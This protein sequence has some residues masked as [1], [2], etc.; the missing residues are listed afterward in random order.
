WDN[1]FIIKG[2]KDAAEI[3]K[4][5]GNEEEYERIS[6]I[7]DTFTTSLY[8]SINLA[9]KVRGIDYIPGCVELGDFDATS[10]TVALTPC[11]ELKNLP[12]P[13]VFNTFEK[14][15][16]FFLN[17]KNGNLD[18]INYTP[19]E[20]RLIGSYILLDQPDRAHELIAF[21]L[22]DQRPPGW[23]HWAEIVWNDF[24]KPN[25]IG[26]MPHTW[27]GSDFIN[28]IRSMFVYENEYDASLVIASALY[29]EWIDDP[30][31]MAVNNLPTYFGNLNYE[32]LKSGNSYHFDITGD[33]KLPSNGIKI[34]NFNSKKMPKAVWINGKNSTEFSADEISVRVFP[35]ELIIE[36]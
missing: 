1:F 27:V 22:D 30:D 29:Q 14:Y 36:Y 7:R 34:K 2:L 15:Y 6:K 26:D 32:I 21:F 33:L 19:Y 16:Q 11:N 18:W 8:Q 31:G 5:I 9:M 10:T 25:F 4:I 24:R 13:E 23:H 35:A 3:Q 17:R 28:S 20:N 12:K